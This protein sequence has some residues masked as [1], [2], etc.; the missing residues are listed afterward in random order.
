MLAEGEVSWYQKLNM[1][2]EQKKKKRDYGTYLLDDDDS[3]C[4]SIQYVIHLSFVFREPMIPTRTRS[5]YLR[6]NKAWYGLS[7]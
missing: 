1:S 2:K 4:S 7:S 3:F 6:E 5:M